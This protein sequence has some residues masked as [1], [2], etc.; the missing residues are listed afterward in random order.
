MNR[1]RSY[2]DGLRW[3]VLPAMSALYVAART[4]AR[5]IF[6]A[7]GFDREVSD[8][9]SSFALA[10]PA[11]I[12]WC[13]LIR[14]KEPHNRQKNDTGQAV[15]AVA[16]AVFLALFSKGLTALRRGETPWPAAG[17]LS[18][19]AYCLAGPLT[20]EIVYRGLA[21]SRSKTKTDRIISAVLSTLLFAAAHAETGGFG[22]A[23]AGGAL[24]S[25][26]YLRWDMLRFPIAA[27]C[28]ANLLVLFFPDVLPPH[29]SAAIGTIGVLGLGA[30]LL[31]RKSQIRRRL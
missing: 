4:V 29:L 10:V 2:S 26:L 1:L 30:M 28:G 31:F 24:F 3:I 14:K 8:A 9:L 20:E 18:G 17:F 21:L 22:I 11:L 6:S 12:V 25:L 23:L 27:H 13:C 7:C 19:C 5:F 16:S 15:I